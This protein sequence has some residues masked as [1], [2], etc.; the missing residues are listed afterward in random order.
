MNAL[1]N[2]SVLKM[3]YR[4]MVKTSYRAHECLAEWKCPED[5]LKNVNG[6]RKSYK[7]AET[8]LATIDEIKNCGW[9]RY[10]L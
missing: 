9:D 6:F 8:R 1:L 5:A 7:K 3:L 4:T 2:G 10:L